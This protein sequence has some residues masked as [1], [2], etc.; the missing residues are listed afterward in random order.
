MVWAVGCTCC[1]QAACGPARMQHP[2]VHRL[3]A[4][5]SRPSRFLPL[6]AGAQVSEADARSYAGESGLLYYEASAKDNVNVSA[7]F[8]DVADK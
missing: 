3:S 4:P 5:P 8:E 6:A 1:C 7:V 2:L